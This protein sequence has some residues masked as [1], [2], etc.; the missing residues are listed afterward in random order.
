MDQDT[1]EGNWKPIIVADGPVSAE[2]CTLETEID[3]VA[4]IAG[5]VAEGHGY[6]QSVV[7]YCTELARLAE[8]EDV[9]RFLHELGWFFQR[10][11]FRSL[12][13]SPATLVLKSFSFHAPL[14]VVCFETAGFGCFWFYVSEHFVSLF[15]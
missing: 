3:R 7:L 6:D 12:N 1:L 10:S 13:S 9:T 15:L 8:E 2:I 14:M 4:F 5:R 11:Y